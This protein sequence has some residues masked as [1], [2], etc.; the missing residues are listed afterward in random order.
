[1]WQELQ[2][3]EKKAP[4]ALSLPSS[5]CLCKASSL[6]ALL[7][8]TVAWKDILCLFKVLLIKLMTFT[9]HLLSKSHSSTCSKDT[10][11]HRPWHGFPSTKMNV[12]WLLFYKGALDAWHVL[13]VLAA[14]KVSHPLTHTCHLVFPILLA[15]VFAPSC[16]TLCDPMDCSPLGSSVCGIFQRILEWLPSPGNLPKGRISRGSRRSNPHLCHL[17][18]WQVDSLPPS[19]W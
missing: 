3:L 18:D 9:Q 19:P 11:T 8:L 13:L 1:M 14:K 10:E 17:L 7:S 6:T 16:P 2:P 12:L 4:K 5:S 15:R